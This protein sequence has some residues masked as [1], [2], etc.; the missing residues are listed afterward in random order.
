MPN[1]VYNIL[2]CDDASVIEKI[3]NNKGYLD[4]NCILPMPDYI[5]NTSCGSE[6]N[7]E[8]SSIIDI[9]KRQNTQ[10]EFTKE[11]LKKGAAEGWYGWSKRVWGC[12]WNACETIIISPYM[13]SFTTAWT[14]PLGFIKKLSN[15]NKHQPIYLSYKSEGSD[16]GLKTIIFMNGEVIKV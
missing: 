15:S 12:K 9:N 16:G 10:R 11:E 4:F 2:I 5:K 13:V 14:P 8:D 1:Y 7:Y 3:I 6:V